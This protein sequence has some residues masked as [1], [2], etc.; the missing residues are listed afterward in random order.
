MSNL[1]KFADT[2]LYCAIKSKDDCY[3]LQQNLVNITDWGRI[4]R[5]NLNSDKC[6][7]LSLG[8]QVS[9]IN[10]Y[11]MSYPDGLHQLIRVEEETDLGVL[12]SSTLKFSYHAKGN[13]TEG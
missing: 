11:S 12:F 8:T 1:Y 3:I 4:W 2:K 5:T 6:K 10:T 9:I 7:V 13:S